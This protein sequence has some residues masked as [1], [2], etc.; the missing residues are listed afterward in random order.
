MPADEFLG[1]STQD[2]VDRESP[3]LLGQTRVEDDVEQKV[4]QFL[5][6]TGKV[7]GIDRVDDLVDFFDEHRPERI[8]VL[9]AI[10]RASLRPAK[11]RHD[12]DEA[13]EPRLT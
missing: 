12:F 6:Q 3:V 4:A 10:P 1:D 5:G 9:L 2:I 7:P 8:E 13:L 11:R